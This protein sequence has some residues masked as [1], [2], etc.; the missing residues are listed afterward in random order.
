MDESESRW[1]AWIVRRGQEEG[2]GEA[3]WSDWEILSRRFRE[4]GVQ[5]DRAGDGIAAYGAQSPL[6]ERFNDQ[7]EFPLMEVLHRLIQL[8]VAGRYTRCPKCGRLP[9]PEERP[10]REWHLRSTIEPLAFFWICPE[11]AKKEEEEGEAAPDD[12]T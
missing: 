5:V 8:D 4:F 3:Q 1:D 9:R 2:W 11:C 12:A 10:I 6:F 7:D